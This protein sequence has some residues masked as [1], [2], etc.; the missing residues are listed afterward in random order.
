M[1]FRELRNAVVKELS[2]YLKLPVVLSSQVNPEQE[3]PFLIYSSTAPYI[4]EAGMG[5]FRQVRDRDGRIHEVRKEQPTCTLSFTACS[6]NREEP[7]VLGEDEALELA[8]TA[9]GWFLHVG[10]DR[11]SGLGVTVVDASNVQERSFLQVDEEARRY[12]FDVSIRYVRTDIRAIAT[13]AGVTTRK[14]EM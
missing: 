11:L 12:G 8:E 4:P 10:Y 2:E 14:K 6:M 13:I 9:L 7:L 1:T 5:E 3:Y